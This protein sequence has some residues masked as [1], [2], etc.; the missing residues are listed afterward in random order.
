MLIEEEEVTI[1]KPM[2]AGNDAKI[3]RLLKAMKND[4]R[5][6]DEQEETMD[7]LSLLWQNGE[8]PAKVSKD[9]VK[10]STLVGDTLELYY[11]IMKL[12]PPVY[13]ED[14]KEKQA[15]IDGEK[16]IILS[17]YLKAGE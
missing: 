11:E 14:K 15:K 5:F 9:V 10:K 4:P 2:V 13:L 1:E 6:T 3:I 16:Q 8:I 17:C 12:V 7:K